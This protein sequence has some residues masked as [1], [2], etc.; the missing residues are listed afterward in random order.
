MSKF[1]LGFTIAISFILSSCISFSTL[2]T[3][4]VMEENESTFGVGAIAVPIDGEIL[5]CGTEIYARFP[6]FKKADFGLKAFGLP[7]FGTI[8]GDIKYQVLDDP[9]YLSFDLALTYTSVKGGGSG[10]GVIPAVF[11]G[12]DRIFGGAKMIYSSIEYEGL[13]NSSSQKVSV[14]FPGVFLGGSIG[15]K[16]R[17]LPVVN[18]YFPTGSEDSFFIYNL[19]LQYTFK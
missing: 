4:K 2:Q 8:T 6:F 19:G 9:F 16:W 12:T 18:L 11:I 5:C 15:D 10:S 14:D 7:G 13:F 17:V 1:Y 3:P